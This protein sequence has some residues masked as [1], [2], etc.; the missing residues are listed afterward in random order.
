M[1]SPRDVVPKAP[2]LVTAEMSQTFAPLIMWG[3]C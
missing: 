1:K 2:S 3:S